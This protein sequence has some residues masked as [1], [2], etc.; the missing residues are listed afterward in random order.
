MA[1]HEDNLVDLALAA[2][3]FM[4]LVSKSN[5]ERLHEV[6]ARESVIQAVL[7]REAGRG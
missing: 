7:D 2:K 5:A 3:S 1:E 6:L 4:L